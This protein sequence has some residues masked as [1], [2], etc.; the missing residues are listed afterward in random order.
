MPKQKSRKSLVKRFKITKNGKILR[1][2]AFRR[3]LKS[4][5]TKKSLTNLKKNKRV[6]GF[7]EKKLRKAM[8]VKKAK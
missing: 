6:T 1:K 4:K 2:Q 7:Y 5:K 3:H 8:G